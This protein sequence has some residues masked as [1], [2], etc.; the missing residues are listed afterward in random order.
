VPA[1]NEMRGPWR[2]TRAISVRWI[3]DTYLRV[4]PKSLQKIA[5]LPPEFGKHGGL[6]N[7]RLPEKNTSMTQVPIS[8]TLSVCGEVAEGLKAAVC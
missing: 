5:S 3:L 4:C 7:R 8:R 1:L 2:I 6:K